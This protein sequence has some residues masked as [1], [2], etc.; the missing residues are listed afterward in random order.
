MAS[1]QIKKV[2][3]E[4]INS[5]DEKLRAISVDVKKKNVNFIFGAVN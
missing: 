5:Y 1:E 2:I 4:T 3:E